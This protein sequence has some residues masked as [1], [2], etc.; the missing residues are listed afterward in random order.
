MIGSL[1]AQSVPPTARTQRGR[2][3]VAVGNGPRRSWRT[4]S[5]ATSLQNTRDV[6]SMAEN[7]DLC[8]A[9]EFF[10][11]TLGLRSGLRRQARRRR[12][13]DQAPHRARQSRAVTTVEP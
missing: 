2:C 5:G 6:T 11:A 10:I 1:C 12:L 9:A 4:S 3:R 8:D 13:L 7:Q